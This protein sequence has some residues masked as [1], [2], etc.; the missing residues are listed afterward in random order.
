VLGQQPV[1]PLGGLQ[2]QQQPLPRID[3]DVAA[4]A[5]MGLVDI[6]VLL[7]VATFPV[8]ANPPPGQPATGLVL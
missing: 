1:T 6:K 7:P 8:P 4:M 2:R 3:V 5:T